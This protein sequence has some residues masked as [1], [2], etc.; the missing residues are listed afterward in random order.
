[1]RCHA[2]AGVLLALSPLSLSAGA[3]D[4]VMPPGQILAATAHAPVGPLVAA[5]A[6]PRSAPT[7]QASADESADPQALRPWLLVLT[8]V[9][10]AAMMARRRL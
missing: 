7:P 1:M 3:V 10:L 4:T 5:I 2:V 9:V 8:G 6:Q